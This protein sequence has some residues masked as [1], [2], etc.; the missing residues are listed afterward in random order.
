MHEG[1]ILRSCLGD[2]VCGGADNQP[3]FLVGRWQHYVCFLVFAQTGGS[4]CVFMPLFCG[5][6]RSADDAAQS[7]V[8]SVLL[9]VYALKLGATLF[10]QQLIFSCQ[11]A[12]TCSNVYP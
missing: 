11:I 9:L 8:L 10:F 7:V 1:S 12:F 3:A 2:G 5:R 6:G 4:G